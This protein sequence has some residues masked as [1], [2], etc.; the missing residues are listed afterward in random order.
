MNTVKRFSKLLGT[1]TLV[2]AL[3][4]LDMSMKP[5]TAF[6]TGNDLAQFV[7]R[8]SVFNEA[9]ASI[10][11]E[12]GG[13]MA[14]HIRFM[15]MLINGPGANGYPDGMDG[16]EDG[17]LGMIRD[18][19]GPDALGGGLLEAGYSSCSDVPTTGNY[20]MTDDEGTFKMYFETPVKTIPTGYTDAGATFDRRVV[21]QF[22]GTTFM[23]IEF[24]CDSTVGWMRM[25]MG[26]TGMVS[27]TLREI[28]VYYDTE[29]A[30]DA[31][32]ELYMTYEPGTDS[33]NGNEY[34]IAKFETLS[35]ST[36]KFWI[37]RSVDADSGDNGFRAAAYGDSSTDVVNAYMKFASAIT[38]TST[39]HTDNGTIST[40]DVACIDY[41]APASA[42]DGGSGC[43]SLTLDSTAGSPISDSSDGFSISWA[44]D[45]TNGLKADMTALAEPTNP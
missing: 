40:G 41:S 19:T 23:N 39:D 33:S 11:D 43:A 8:I 26:D 16:P 34:F 44:G 28:E 30:A 24:N 42:T 25:S 35:S 2:L 36:Y 37:I 1:A 14:N 32:L 12:N 20:S 10:L 3:S 22:D 15:Y 29:T 45:T 31:H 27:G 5:K 13:A 9:Q 7:N 4:M 18:I 21:V 17:F 6:Q 38:D